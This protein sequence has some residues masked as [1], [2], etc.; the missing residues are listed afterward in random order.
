VYRHDPR[1]RQYVIEHCWLR[2][3][4]PCSARH[5]GT[6]EDMSKQPSLV[7]LPLTTRGELEPTA[8]RVFDDA[9]VK[10]TA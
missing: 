1:G 4:A 5:L 9:T 7:C 6:G 10:P 2:R 3:T 8:Q